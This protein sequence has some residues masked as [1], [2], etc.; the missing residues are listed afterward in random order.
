MRDTT[1]MYRNQADAL[2]NLAPEQFKAAVLA[3][4]DYEMDGVEPSDDPVALAMWMMAKPLIDKRQR[5]YEKNCEN[6]RKG[7]RPKK[8]EYNPTETETKP[9]DNPTETQLK[10]NDNPNKPTTNPT[11]TLKEKG[12]RIKDKEY[13]YQDIIDHLNQK[14][15]TKFLSSSKDTRKHIKARM[16]EGFTFDDFIKVIDGRIAAWGNDAKM[17]EFIR[18]Q[19]IFGTKF[20]SY[21]NARP[22]RTSSGANRFNNF[23][24]RQ[25]DYDTLERQLLQAQGGT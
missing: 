20:E 10:P 21:L 24:A 6:G 13:P 17:R 25:Y 12:K 11:E 15:G 14:A 7:G 9:S 1:M 18:P 5:N 16:D 23:P 22:Q 3:L 8:T 19:T 2:R 4:W